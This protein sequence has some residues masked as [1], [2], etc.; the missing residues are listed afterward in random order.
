MRKIPLFGKGI[1][2]CALYVGSLDQLEL[3]G[4][5]YRV[6]EKCHIWLENK[7]PISTGLRKSLLLLRVLSSC[8]L[9]ASVGVTSLWNQ[10][11]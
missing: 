9:S 2:E 8:C 10:H 5:M 11:G 7:G 6:E 1:N 4:G 3:V